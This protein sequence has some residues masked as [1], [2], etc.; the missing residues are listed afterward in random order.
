MII[1]YYLFRGFR[2]PFINLIHLGVRRETRILLT[3][4][5]LENDQL[6]EHVY[7]TEIYN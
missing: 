6:H 4:W 7:N 3:S 5:S 1:V 2:V